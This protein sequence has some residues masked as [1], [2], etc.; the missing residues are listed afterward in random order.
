[1]TF[2]R[3]GLSRDFVFATGVRRDLGD[4]AALPRDVVELA[5]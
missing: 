3:L 2:Y 4:L 5:V 1:M